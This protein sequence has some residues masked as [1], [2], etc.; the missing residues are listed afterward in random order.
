MLVLPS[1]TAPVWERFLEEHKTLVYKFIV[2]DI[3]KGIKEDKE[4]IDLFKFDD[5][6]MHAW[7]KNS[8]YLKTLNEAM[9]VFIDAEEYEYAQKTDNI[10]K[11]Y[12]IESIIKKSIK[13]E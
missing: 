2:R 5:N 10:I 4:V 3:K 9:K 8:N 13:E 11:M 6:S 7:I 1:K 12:H